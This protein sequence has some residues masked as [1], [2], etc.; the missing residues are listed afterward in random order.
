MLCAVSCTLISRLE[1]RNEC[2]LFLGRRPISGRA[3]IVF[4]F[5][6]NA[7]LECGSIH[8][9]KAVRLCTGNRRFGALPLTRLKPRPFKRRFAT[10][11]LTTELTQAAHGVGATLLSR[12]AVMKLKGVCISRTL[13]HSQLRPRETTGDLAGDRLRALRGRVTSALERTISGKK[14]AVHS[15]IG[16]RK[17]VNVFRLRLCICKQGKRSYGIYKDALRQVIAKN[18]KAICYPTYRGG[19]W[20][21]VRLGYIS[22]GVK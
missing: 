2:K 3:R 5:A 7:R 16:S 14:D 12:G 1:V 17:R 10:R 8:G 9:F 4:R 11:S 19:W 20:Y 22:G 15:C 6:S 13:F 18:E 21:E